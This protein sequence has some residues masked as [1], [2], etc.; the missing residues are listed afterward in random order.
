M[1]SRE[2]G[3]TYREVTY[4]SSDLSWTAPPYAY[5]YGCVLAYA[6]RIGIGICPYTVAHTV[7]YRIPYTVAYKS[8]WPFIFI[9]LGVSVRLLTRTTSLQRGPLEAP[10]APVACS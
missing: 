8:Y 7:V 10:I 5:A 9:L 1:Q 4:R 6:E 3:K 2:P